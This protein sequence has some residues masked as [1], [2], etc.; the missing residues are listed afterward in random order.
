MSE[1]ESGEAR[2]ASFMEILSSVGSG[3]ALCMSAIVGSSDRMLAID[4]TL[5]AI[6]GMVSAI[7]WQGEK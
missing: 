4:L 7:Y 1:R 3:G 5:M 2:F 6:F